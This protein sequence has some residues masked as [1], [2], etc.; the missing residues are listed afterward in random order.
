MGT[1]RHKGWLAIILAIGLVLWFWFEV[2]VMGYI[3]AVMLFAVVGFAA[4]RAAWHCY[5]INRTHQMAISAISAIG[6]WREVLLVANDNGPPLT[7]G[8]LILGLMAVGL[9]WHLAAARR[10]AYQSLRLGPLIS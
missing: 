10:V 7:L 9:F 4:A 3:G 1:I 5:R 6:C 2:R 8:W